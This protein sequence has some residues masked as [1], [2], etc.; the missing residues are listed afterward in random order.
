MSES[1]NIIQSTHCVCQMAYKCQNS[2]IK[3]AKDTSM[4]EPPS[5]KMLLNH[6]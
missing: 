4:V 3:V 2:K 1:K 5:T 6:S